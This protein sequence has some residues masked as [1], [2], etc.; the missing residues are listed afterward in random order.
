MKLFDVGIRRAAFVLPLLALAA[1]ACVATAKDDEVLDPL[2]NVNEAGMTLAMCGTVD[3]FEAP[4]PP[5]EDGALAIDGRRWTVLAHATLDAT[6]LLSP[7]ENICIKATMDLQ[8]RIER[9][10]VSQRSP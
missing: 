7:G 10:V 9:C 8:S 3:D 1:T 2:R 4:R 5:G 6:D